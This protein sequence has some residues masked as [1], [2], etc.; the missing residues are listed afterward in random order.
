MRHE[1]EERLQHML[2]AAKEAVA[3][4]RGLDLKGLE[5]DRRT[6]LA[7]V[8]EVEIVGEAA[9]KITETLRSQ[10]REIPWAD[11]I[12]MRHRLVHAY[13]EI[14][15]EILWKTVQEALPPLITALEEILK[16]RR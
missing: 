7:L 8:K 14:D 1:D 6:T 12:G 10:M 11:I 9:S 3:F 5:K 13:F 2:D 4:A 16:R 15:V